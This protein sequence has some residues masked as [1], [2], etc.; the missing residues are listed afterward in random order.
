MSPTSTR[1]A[2]E[3]GLHG[4]GI[5]GGKLFVGVQFGREGL[6]IGLSLPSSNLRTVK[7]VDWKAWEKAL[8]CM[9]KCTVE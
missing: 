2:N 8:D 5:V 3:G 4:E 6:E 9:V 7:V 1:D